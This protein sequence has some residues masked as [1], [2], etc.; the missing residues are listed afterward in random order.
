MESFN[1]SKR[2]RAPIWIGTDVIALSP[3]PRYFK[4]VR[5]PISVGSD[6]RALASR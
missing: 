3:R 5:A 4:L 1:D 2:V 6:V